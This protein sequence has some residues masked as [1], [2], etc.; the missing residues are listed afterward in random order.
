MDGRFLGAWRGDG[1]CFENQSKMIIFF[2]P[3]SKIFILPPKDVEYAEWQRR[4]CGHQKKVEFAESQN[5]E[6]KSDFFEVICKI[7]MLPKKLTNFRKFRTFASNIA[8]YK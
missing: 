8:F 5:S 7:I 3:G 1:M 6:G 2:F 4:K